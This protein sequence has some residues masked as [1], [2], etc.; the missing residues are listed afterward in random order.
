MFVRV[1]FNGLIR[2]RISK[3]TN[4]YFTFF[5]VIIFRYVMRM[6]TA[7]YALD[8][9]QRHI[10]DVIIGLMSSFRITPEHTR[11]SFEY[12]ANT[13]EGYDAYADQAVN[14]PVQETDKPTS[15]QLPKSTPSQCSP[16][17]VHTQS[18]ADMCDDDN[19]YCKIS[20][21]SEKSEPSES[22]DPNDSDSTDSLG[23]GMSPVYVATRGQFCTAMQNRIRICPRYS[24]CTDN[25]CNNF[26][27]KPE[28]ICPHVVRGS[29]CENKECELI[30]IR[31]CRKGKKCTNS[32]CSFRH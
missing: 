20:E 26:H 5:L 27:I 14:V 21:N 8:N 18:W 7:E 11:E 19:D 28:Y 1:N 2:K 30:V 6:C 17:K 12:F 23:L 3:Y 16:L 15:D 31:A 13:Y 9:V 29:Y 25:K 32:E 22:T 10:L 4:A 24:T